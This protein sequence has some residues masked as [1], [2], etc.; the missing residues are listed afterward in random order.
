MERRL[1]FAGRRLR[2]ELR[3]SRRRATFER[4]RRSILTSQRG[5]DLRRR[6]ASLAIPALLGLAVLCACGRTE[7]PSRRVSSQPEQSFTLPA[8]DG[9]RFALESVCKDNG[10]VVLSFWTTWCAPCLQEFP[11]LEAFHKQHQED[12]VYLLAIEVGSHPDAVRRLVRR[13]GISFPVL[14]DTDMSIAKRFRVNTF[15]HV[16]V[17]ANGCRVVYEG[18]GIGKQFNRQIAGLR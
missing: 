10:V 9:S 11:L 13:S 6:A 4:S 5:H 17:L 1:R 3:D 12:G 18:T 2:C 7:P 16:I 14:L 8:I 15:P